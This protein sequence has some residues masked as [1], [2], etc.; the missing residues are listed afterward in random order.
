ML[1]VIFA[2]FAASLM[3]GTGAAPHRRL[4][5]PAAI[6]TAVALPSVVGSTDVK[7]ARA[8]SA[9]KLEHQQLVHPSRKDENWTVASGPYKVRLY[10][11]SI[12]R[13]YMRVQ[14]STWALLRFLRSLDLHRQCGQRDFFNEDGPGRSARRICRRIRLSL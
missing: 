1:G 7:L 3:L 13:L 9:P 10:Q 6:L 5:A 12:R 4:L 11:L 2:T 8:S 14:A